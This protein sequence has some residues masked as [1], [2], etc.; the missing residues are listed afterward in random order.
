ME[1]L[2]QGGVCGV[3]ACELGVNPEITKDKWVLKIIWHL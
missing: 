2:P 1:Y 3:C